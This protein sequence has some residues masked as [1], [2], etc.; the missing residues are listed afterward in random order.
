L[1]IVETEKLPWELIVPNTRGGDVYRKGI[2][3]AEG[4][5]QVSY[6][7]RL[8]RFGEG[9]RS[10]ASIRHRHD[11]EQLRFAVSGKMDLGVGVLNEGEVGYFPANAFYGPQKCEGAM[12]LIAQ[13]GDRFIRKTDSDRAVVELSA[14]GE[15]VDGVYR[16]TGSNGKTIK[17]DPLNA[18]WE[19][20]FQQPYVPQRSRYTQPIILSPAGFGW[21][22]PE[23]A[24]QARRMGVFTEN[25][26]ALEMIAWTEDGTFHSQLAVGDE[27][28]TLMFTTKGVFSC[29]GRQFG[30]LTSIWADP[31]ESVKIEAEQ[32]SE[33]FRLNLPAPAS[34]I[35]LGLA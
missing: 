19:Q 12:I 13:W 23:G 27:R 17:K 15:F 11:F 16:S 8:E 14:V 26:V 18:I 4:G 29:D 2:R 30:A 33:L 3:D 34:R 22:S 28:P 9:D 21:S 31:G 5:H 32:G 1:H 10:Y 24:T 25:G 6:D 35:T 20:V 7:V